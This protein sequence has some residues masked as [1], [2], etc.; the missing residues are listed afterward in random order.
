M[1][2]FIKRLVIIF[3]MVSI[4]GGLVYFI[5]SLFH[6]PNCFDG[7]Q[8][9]NE[10]GIDCG[11]SCEEECYTL[12]DLE[13]VRVDSIVMVKDGD[14]YDVAS[15]IVNPNLTHGSGD[16]SYKIDLMRG[17]TV[18][19]TKR[20]E[21]YI[22]PNEEKYL[23][24]LGI[25]VSDTPE[26]AVIELNE[27]TPEEYPGKSN[28]KLEVVKEDYRYNKI[29]GAFFETNF[30]LVNR[31]EFNL[32]Q[33]DIVAV[34]KDEDDEIIALNKGFINSV[35]QGEARDH[36]FFW[37]REIPVTDDI[38]VLIEVKSNVFDFDNIKYD[39]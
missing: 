34:V 29:G 36:R 26:K 12:P 31:S 1:T 32:K 37:P 28:P 10:D 22:L 39:L 7:K 20:G 4:I 19:G 8:N 24:E 30:T 6:K 38:E 5:F 13:R 15:K 25:P 3:V 9:G 14:S 16:V 21:T 17:E 27:G 33:L 18:V 23:V 11:G 2:R 35:K